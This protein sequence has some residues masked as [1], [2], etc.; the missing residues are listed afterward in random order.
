VSSVSIKNTLYTW[1]PHPLRCYWDRVENSELNTRLARGA[2][3]SLVGTAISRPL[4]LAASIFVARLL[5]KE[6]FGEFGIIRGTIETF[7]TFAGLSLGLTATKHVAEFRTRDPGRAGRILVLSNLTA[8]G[9][10]SALGL[11]LVVVAPWFAA[12]ALNA[13]HLRGSLCTGS[14]LLLLYALTGAQTGALSGFEA[15]RTVARVNLCVGLVA[16]PLLIA[17]AYVGG[18]EGAVW[19]MTVALGVHAILNH[20]ALRA[21]ASRAAVPLRITGCMREWSVLWQFSLPAVIT[22]GVT[23]LGTWLCPLLLVQQPDGYREM[24]V[25]SAAS[26]WFLALACLPNVLGRVATPMLAERHS[27]ADHAGSRKIFRLTVAI[28]VTATLPI[29]VVASL[30]SPWI[31]L[32]YGRE[33]AR[34]WPTFVVILL[35]AA[36][37]AVI[38]PAE[39]VITAHGRMWTLLLLY[40]GLAVFTLLFTLWLIGSGAFGMALARLIAYAIHVALI[41]L[42]AMYVLRTDWRLGGWI[43]RFLERATRFASR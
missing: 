19:G 32:L 15:F 23:L 24:G 9:V 10:G 2:F 25:F 42:V 36:A 38:K 34:D 26:Y 14:L 6:V 28:N 37:L 12:G 16:F 22:S 39:R 33:F 1:C 27:V 7:G 31:V 21:E 30:A 17:G 18:L 43:P 20:F 8:V 11:A 3:W 4:M 5:G 40:T 35:C 13:P 41:N 29:V